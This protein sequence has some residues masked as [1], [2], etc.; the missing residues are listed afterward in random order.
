M[1]M[2]RIARSVIAV[3]LF[4]SFANPSEAWTQNRYTPVASSRSCCP[5]ALPATPGRRLV[6]LPSTSASIV[7]L[8]FST[9]SSTAPEASAA[10][11]EASTSTLTQDIIAKLR[12]REL[13]REL[14]ERS[15]PDHGTT[16]QLRSRLREAMGWQEECV[17]DED[18]IEDDCRPLE[19]SDLFE[20]CAH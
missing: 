9:H 10:A 15:L 13:R 18:G 12:F 1:K 16:R 19:V 14:V 3:L 2:R 17:V 6:P 11:A 5:Q 20:E 8:Y 7:T 4:G